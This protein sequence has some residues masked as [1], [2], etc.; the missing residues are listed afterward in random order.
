IARIAQSSDVCQSHT[1]GFLL[2]ALRHAT[3]LAAIA[4]RSPLLYDLQAAFVSDRLSQGGPGGAEI[5]HAG[6]VPLSLSHL[7][8]R[9]GPAG[10]GSVS[11][12]VSAGVGGIA[13]SAGGFELQP[14]PAREAVSRR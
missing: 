6:T 9:D 12:P 13:G 10:V 7:P 5:E 2:A 1:S 3:A 11:A 14:P 8:A 4:P